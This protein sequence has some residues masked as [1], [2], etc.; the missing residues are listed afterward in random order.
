MSHGD[1]IGALPAGFVITASTANTPVAAAEDV[2]R[3]FYGSAISS[4]SCSYPSRQKNAGQ[5]PV[6]YL[7]VQ[8]IMVNEIFCQSCR[9]GN[10]PAGWLRKK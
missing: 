4:G 1:S 3:N 10:P 6:Q 8:K 2:K 5:L 7:P 9:R